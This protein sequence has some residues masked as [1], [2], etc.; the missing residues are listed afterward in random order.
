[1]EFYSS[2]QRKTQYLNNLNLFPSKKLFLNVEKN[3]EIEFFNGLKRC[4]KEDFNK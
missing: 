4:Y 1:M 3:P 2:N